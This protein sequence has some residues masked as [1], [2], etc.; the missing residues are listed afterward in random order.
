MTEAV[1]IQKPVQ[2][3]DFYMITASVMKEFKSNNWFK[4]CDRKHCVK[5]V[6]FLSYSGPY[7]SRIFPHSDWYLSVFSPNAG[8]CRKNADQNNS[9]YGH[10]LR[11]ESFQVSISP[12]V[13]VMSYRLL[14][15]WAFPD[16]THI[17]K[18]IILTRNISLNLVSES[19]MKSLI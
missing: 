5:S 7:F 8:K 14:I 15:Y 13:S 17:L 19:E 3:T 18:I 9:E 4:T 11:S 2:W 16:L 6:R 12:C 10:F 1:I